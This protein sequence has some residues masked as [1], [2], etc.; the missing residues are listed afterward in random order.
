MCGYVCVDLARVATALLEAGANEDVVDV[1]AAAG[2]AVPRLALRVIQHRHVHL[3]QDLRSRRCTCMVPIV[4]LQIQ[5][6]IDEVIISGTDSFLVNS[7]SL[8]LPDKFQ[9]RKEGY[10]ERCAPSR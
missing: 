2:V 7:L 10:R 6:A 3:L 9:I 8:F 4:G 1:L 5:L